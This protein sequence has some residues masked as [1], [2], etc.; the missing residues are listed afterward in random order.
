MKYILPLILLI[1]ISCH[2]PSGKPYIVFKGKIH[3]I[4]LNSRSFVNNGEIPEKHTCF[5]E[6]V[7]PHLKWS[8]VPQGT[9]SFVIIMEDPDAFLIDAVH[10]IIYNIPP[11][12]RELEENVMKAKWLPNDA[13]QGTNDF[14]GTGYYGPCSILR[15]HKYVFSI[16]AIDKILSREIGIKR[17]HLLDSMAN[18][19]IGFGKLEGKF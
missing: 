11:N 17:R 1:F 8:N 2:N 10:W 13:I 14:D 9:K 7:S 19:I 6:N 3:K 15:K 5:D 16:F 12:Y 4:K 18:H